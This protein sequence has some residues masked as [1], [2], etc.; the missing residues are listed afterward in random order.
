MKR[1]MRRAYDRVQHDRLFD[2]AIGTGAFAAL[3]HR[4]FFHRRIGN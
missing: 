2:L 4:V 3:A 1:W